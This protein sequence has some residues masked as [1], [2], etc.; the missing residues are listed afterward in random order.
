MLSLTL[1]GLAPPTGTCSAGRGGGGTEKKVCEKDQFIPDDADSHAFN[2]QIMD[3]QIVFCSK[4]VKQEG[5]LIYIP[6]HYD[7]VISMMNLQDSIQMLLYSVV[8][9]TKYH[10]TSKHP[11]TQQ[12]ID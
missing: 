7:H 1:W 8:N 12:G 2:S 10:L 4:R 3:A 11:I 5:R 6:G 9:R